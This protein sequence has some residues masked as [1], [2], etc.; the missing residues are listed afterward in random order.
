MENKNDTT[1]AELWY[2]KSV[3]S[4]LLDKELAEC[5]GNEVMQDVQE[6][7]DPENWTIYDIQLALV[8]VLKK[9]LNI[10]H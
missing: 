10:N 1:K 5:F 4:V 6:C 2:V 9:H 8:R 7:A 3:I